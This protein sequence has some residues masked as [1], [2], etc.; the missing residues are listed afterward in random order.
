MEREALDRVEP[1]PL[2]LRKI[3]ARR[4]ALELK[5][6]DMVNLGVGMPDAIGVVANE[7]PIHEVIAL[8]VDPGIIGGSPWAGSTSVRLSTLMR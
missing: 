6:N 1:L 8:T 7:E 2:D 4:A 5:S 3:L